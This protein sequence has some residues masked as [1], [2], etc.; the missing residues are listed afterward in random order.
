MRKTPDHTLAKAARRR[1]YTLAELLSG[2]RPGDMPVD[3]AWDAIAP[4]GREFGAVRARTRLPKPA[5]G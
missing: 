3:R 1:S 2:M 5:K 4:V